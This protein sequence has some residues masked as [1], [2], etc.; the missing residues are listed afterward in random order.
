MRRWFLN[1]IGISSLLLWLAITGMWVRSFRAAD[2]LETMK[3]TRIFVLFSY[4]GRLHFCAG[5]LH[6]WPSDPPPIWNADWKVFLA[7]SWLAPEF[8]GSLRYYSRQQVSLCPGGGL[9]RIF[10]DWA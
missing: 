9:G 7:P 5:T 4:C 10:E 2:R 8:E 6:A 1:I 3:S